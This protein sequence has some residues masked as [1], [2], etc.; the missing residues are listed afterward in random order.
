[1][2]DSQ[3]TEGKINELIKGYVKQTVKEMEMAR[4]TSGERLDSEG[5][6]LELDI[7]SDFRAGYKEA[8]AYRD[9]EAVEESVNTLLERNGIG[10]DNKK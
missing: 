6:D 7:I 9:Y 10:V 2:S 1:M 3:L 8:L 5:V 4:A